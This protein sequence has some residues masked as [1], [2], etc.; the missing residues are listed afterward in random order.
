SHF[1]K[2]RTHIQRLEEAFELLDAAS[3][4][5]H[6]AE[7]A[8][9]LQDISAPLEKSD[10]ARERDD[11]IVTTAQRAAHYEVSA[12]GSL[13]ASATTLGAEE[14]ADIL[15]RTLEEEKAAEAMLQ[16]LADER[17]SEDVGG[18]RDGVTDQRQTMVA[19]V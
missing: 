3:G 14:I 15:R 4:G 6:C 7:M 17:I 10:A 13:V 19:R 18:P 2:T 16:S 8:S 11:R 9:I 1:E 5:R 12:Y